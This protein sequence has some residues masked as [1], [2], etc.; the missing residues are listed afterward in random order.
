ML[1]D[2][3]DALGVVAWLDGGWGVDALVGEQTRPHRDVDLV[4]ARDDLSAVRSLL[5]AR[6][7]VELRDWLPT[8]LAFRDPHGREVDLHP[9]DPDPDGGGEQLLPDGGRWRYG[10]PAGGTVAGRPV[11]CASADD[12][13][14]MHEGYELRDVD[15]HDLRLLRRLV[16]PGA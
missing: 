14:R 8:S 10:P 2:E 12:Q 4:V 16:D 11:R 9:V 7:Y 3:L 13:L 5:D 1:L 15:Q 6:G